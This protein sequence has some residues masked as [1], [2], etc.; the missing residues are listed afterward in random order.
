MHRASASNGMKTP[1]GITSSSS[2]PMSCWRAGPGSR[3]NQAAPDVDEMVFHFEP[4]ALRVT[5][6]QRR[7]NIAML[8]SGDRFLK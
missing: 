4:G 5:R 2:I 7:E 6:S 8:P 3:T 1:S